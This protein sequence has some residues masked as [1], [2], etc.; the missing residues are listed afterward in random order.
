MSEDLFTRLARR[1]LGDRTDV[2]P[3]AAPAP[4]PFTSD[5]DAD[6]GSEPAPPVA[7]PNAPAAT[8]EIDQRV[9]A[10]IT[11]TTV[12]SAPATPSMR[13]SP[14]ARVD[15]ASVNEPIPPSPAAATTS[16]VEPTAVPYAPRSGGGGVAR[17]EVVEQR[18]AREVQRSEHRVDVRYEVRPAPAATALPPGGPRASDAPAAHTRAPTIE[19]RISRLEIGE[20]AARG[21]SRPTPGE[22]PTPGARPA[23]A[24]ALD[25]YLARRDRS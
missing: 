4:V 7:A 25:E 14:A 20:P 15:V 17:T 23:P 11:P 5:A 13:A 24:L 10:S 18:T 3:L 8:V 6:A 2:Q 12:V 22:R 21:R 19:I 9:P 1:A 16:P